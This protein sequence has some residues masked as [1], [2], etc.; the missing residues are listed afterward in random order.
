[1]LNAE[2]SIACT[3]L[4]ILND[5]LQVTGKVGC[6]RDALVQIVLRLRDDALK[7]RDVGHNSAIVTDSMYTSGSSFSMPSVLPSVSPGAPPMGYDQRAESGSGLSVLSSSGLYGYG[8]LSVGVISKLLI[9]WDISTFLFCKQ[10]YNCCSGLFGKTNLFCTK[11][12][13]RSAFVIF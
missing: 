13:M 3:T 10:L 9:L 12:M 6:V 5:F 4:L 1:M 8:S 11:E 7:E 2:C